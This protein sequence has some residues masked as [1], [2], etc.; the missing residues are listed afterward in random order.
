MENEIL[1]NDKSYNI[2]GYEIKE[3]KDALNRT[4]KIIEIIAESR[5]EDISLYEAVIKIG[6]K[7][8]NGI[9]NSVWGSNGNNYGVSYLIKDESSPTKAVPQGQTKLF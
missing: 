6:D 4:W 7:T 2:L 1:I 8:M 3:C 9:W 5:F